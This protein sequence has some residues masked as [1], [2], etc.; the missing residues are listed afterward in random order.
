[1]LQRIGA[2]RA[3]SNTAVAAEDEHQAREQRPWLFVVKKN[4]T[5]LERLLHWIR[6][7]VAN[8]VDPE[9]GRKLV[10]QPALSW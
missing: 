4:K 9:T 10:T 3:T 1:M 8:H 6:N 2:T 5:V 7:R